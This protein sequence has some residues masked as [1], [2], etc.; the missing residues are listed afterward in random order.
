[1]LSELL[2][3]SLAYNRAA[4]LRRAWSEF[5]LYA[6]GTR[7]DFRHELRRAWD[8]ARGYRAN[9]VF[10]AEREAS[11]TIQAAERAQ[12]SLRERDVLDAQSALFFAEMSDAHGA[13]ARIAVARARLDALQLAA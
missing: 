6:N 12:L 9:A 10:F 11:A 7:A 5:R 4:I 13:H 3:P 1:M 2:L 8:A